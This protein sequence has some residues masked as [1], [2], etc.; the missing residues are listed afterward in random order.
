MFCSRGEVLERARICDVH[1][2]EATDGSSDRKN[3]ISC[4]VI[5]PSRA[6]RKFTRSGSSDL[7]KTYEPRSFAQLQATVHYLLRDIWWQSTKQSC[8][9]GNQHL[10]GKSGSDLGLAY[11]FV[12]DRLQA[13]R[14]DIISL[15]MFVSNPH[16]VVK[17]LRDII[18]FYVNSMHLITSG[19][20]ALVA[21]PSPTAGDRKPRETPMYGKSYSSAPFQSVGKNASSAPL[22]SISSWFDLHSHESALS[23]SLTTNLSFCRQLPVK[24]RDAVCGFDVAAHYEEF[25]ACTM[26]LS[27]A[28]QLRNIFQHVHSSTSSSSHNIKA[29]G[30]MRLM[31]VQQPTL[32]SAS[33]DTLIEL[34]QYRSKS[35]DDKFA[36]TELRSMS[37]L[38][39]STSVHSALRCVSCVR[40]SNPEGAV[41]AFSAY[42]GISS[43][44]TAGTIKLKMDAFS[45]RTEAETFDRA[46]RLLMAALLHHMLPELRQCR[47]M[48]C[49]LA[50][51]KDG[52][53]DLVSALLCIVVFYQLLSFRM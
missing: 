49:D 32:G 20:G 37:T 44:T 27:T 1:L 13:V 35:F 2:F 39:L 53:I 16:G 19:Y 6:V 18:I 45:G 51:K 17:L 23:S 46:Q 33:V 48:L 22:I 30:A 36:N 41:R 12:M 5:D 4:R 43:T 11:T 24:H 10:L 29:I 26:L 7:H 8:D 3:P 28:R 14:Q 38:G 42:A 47:L 25:S 52:I 21:S 15:N 34:D 50:D 40:R 9:R 31:C